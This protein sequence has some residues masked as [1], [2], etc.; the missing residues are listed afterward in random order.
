MVSTIDEVRNIHP[1]L[2]ANPFLIEEGAKLIQ[3]ERFVDDET[4]R[5]IDLH[6]LDKQGT[7]LYVEVEWSAL[8]TAQIE[9]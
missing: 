9:R 1:I 8:D 2:R 5:R 7:P 4:F 6:L 3:G